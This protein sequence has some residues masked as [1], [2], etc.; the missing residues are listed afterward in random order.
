[1]S[2]RTRAG[3]V[4][5]TLVAVNLAGMT[6]VA[7]AQASDEPTG[8]QAAQRPPSRDRS[9][10]PGTS[11]RK[12]PMSSL[13]PATPG[14]HRPSAWLESPGATRP[15]SPCG[16]PH[17]TGSPAGAWRRSGCWPRP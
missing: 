8:K 3:I 14:G 7:H 5:V 15:R 6:A 17:R 10:R 13:W 9:A 2:K 1:M 4:A 16:L 11:R 12:Q